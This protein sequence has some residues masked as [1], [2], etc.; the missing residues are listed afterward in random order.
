MRKDVW[1]TVR[2]NQKTSGRGVHI[3]P[4]AKTGN[5]NS[6]NASGRGV[7]IQARENNNNNRSGAGKGKGKGK[8]PVARSRW[9]PKEGDF[10][11]IGAK[12]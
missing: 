4:R 11:T 9:P 6:Q 10:P 8:K 2:N 1:N 12:K 5:N 7:H 3:R